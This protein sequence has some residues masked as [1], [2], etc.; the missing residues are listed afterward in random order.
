LSNDFIQ[1]G[2]VLNIPD[3]GAAV[4]QYD[5]TPYEAPDQQPFSQ[6]SFGSDSMERRSMRLPVLTGFP[7]PTLS[8]QASNYSFRRRASTVDLPRRRRPPATMNSRPKGTHL[9]H[10]A[11]TTTRPRHL[12]TNTTRPRH[13]ATTTTPRRIIAITLIRTMPGPTR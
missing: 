5:Q 12:A 2:Q 9:R 6:D 7:I 13:L 1:A 8:S 4:P 11:T 3:G 10:P